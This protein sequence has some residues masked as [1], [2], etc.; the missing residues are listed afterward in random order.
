M[1]QYRPTLLI[2]AVLASFAAGAAEP[3][4]YTQNITLPTGQLVVV[5]EGEFEPHSVG[6][7][8]IRLYAAAN[9]QFPMDDF[10]TGL[11][12]ARDGYLDKTILADIDGDQRQELIVI[13]RSAGTGGYLSAQAFAIGTNTI[14]LRSSVAG[15]PA[16]ADPIAALGKALTADCSSTTP[17]KNQGL[18]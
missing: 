4:R 16:D 18:P 7:Y 12:Q 8:S 2:I 14:V 5:T 3:E 9:L 15:L 11:I 13:A 1:R 10:Q 6:S 17:L